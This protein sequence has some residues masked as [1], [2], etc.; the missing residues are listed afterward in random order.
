MK[1]ADPFYLTAEWSKARNR[2]LARDR[3]ACTRCGIS[4]KGRRQAIIHHI[5]P[6]KQAPH[7]SLTLT[8]LTTLC[9]ICHGTTHDNANGSIRPE[10]PKTGTDGF[11][12]GM[13]WG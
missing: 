5:I 6:R 3:Y 13:G 11:P 9:R 8:N 2:A 7:L 10:A 12:E 4:V 1:I